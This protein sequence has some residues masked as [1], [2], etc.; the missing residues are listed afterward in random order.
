MC[1][2]HRMPEMDLRILNKFL[3]FIS[4]HQLTLHPLQKNFFITR[5]D[6]GPLLPFNNYFS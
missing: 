2:L 1:H 3:F 6:R 4:T 5:P